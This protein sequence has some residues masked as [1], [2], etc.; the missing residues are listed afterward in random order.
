MTHQSGRRKSIL[1]VNALVFINASFY[2]PSTLFNIIYIFLN[3]NV[4]ISS[5]MGLAL[6]F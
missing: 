2:G 5:D 3:N 4:E 1:F 6:L